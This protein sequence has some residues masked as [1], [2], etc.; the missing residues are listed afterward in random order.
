MRHIFAV[1]LLIASIHASADQKTPAEWAESHRPG[2]CDTYTWNMVR[3]FNLLS[4]TPWA[5]QAQL[6]DRP[7][8]DP[9]LLI[10]LDR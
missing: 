2:G 1:V 9:V 5:L 8:P 6:T 7:V 4:A 3:E 10:T